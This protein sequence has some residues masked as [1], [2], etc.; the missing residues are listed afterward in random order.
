MSKRTP[1]NPFPLDIYEFRC[2]RPRG[3]NRRC[4]KKVGMAR[5]NEERAN[6]DFQGTHDNGPYETD[7]QILRFYC[8]VHGEVVAWS[9]ELGDTKV[10]WVYTELRR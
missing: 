1:G 7:D 9:N 10:H 8:P 3:T 6:F 5:W 4:R 2:E